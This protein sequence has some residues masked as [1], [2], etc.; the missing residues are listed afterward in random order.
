MRGRRKDYQQDVCRGQ[1]GKCRDADGVGDAVDETVLGEL[2]DGGEQDVGEEDNT[3]RHVVNKVRAAE[4]M[5]T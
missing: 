5:V 4:R 1:H 3:L 2:G